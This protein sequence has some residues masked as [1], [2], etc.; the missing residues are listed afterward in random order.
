MLG[1]SARRHGR[2]G[3]RRRRHPER[4]GRLLLV[5]DARASG[6]RA[7]CRDGTRAR[8]NARASRGTRRRA[9]RSTRRRPPSSRTTRRSRE[10]L[11]RQWPLYFGRYGEREAAFVQ[12]LAG[13]VPNADALRRF[14]SDVLRDRSTSGRSSRASRRRRSCWRGDPGTSWRR[15]RLRGRS[16][17]AVA[18]A[19]ARGRAG[20]RPF[21]LRRGTGSVS[22]RRAL[23]F[24]GR[25]AGL[26]ESA[27]EAIR[28]GGRSSCR[29]TPSTASAPTRTGR[30]RCGELY[31]LKAARP[32][33]RARCSRGTSTCCSSS[34]PSCAAGRRRWRARLLPG[35]Y[36]LVLPN[37]ARRYRWLTGDSPGH[38][39]RARAGAAGPPRR[40][41]SDVGALVATSANLH[42]GPEPRRLEDVPVE[43]RAGAAAVVDG[44][45][46]PGTP[47][48]VLDLTGRG[49]EGPPRGRRARG[50]G[51]RARG[52]PPS[53][54]ST[55]TISRE[56]PSRRK[57]SST[58]ARPGSRRSIRRSPS[59][60]AA[61]SSAS[62]AQIELIASENFTWPAVLEAVGSVPTNK[63][64]EGYPGRRYYGGCEVVDEIEQTAIDR[65]KELFGAEHANVQPHAG[66]Q[67]NMAVYMA[68][69]AAGRHD[70]LAR[71]LARRPPHAR[72]QGQLLRPAVHD[73]PLRRL[74]RDERRRLRR[75]ARA[76]EGA[77]A[78]AD[79]LRRLRLPAHGRDRPLPRDRGRGRRAAALRH[80]PLRRARRGRAAPEPGRA[81]PTSSP[82][83]RTRRS[84]AR[85]PASSSAARST[86]RRS[87]A[88]SSRGCRAGRS[89]TR[90]R[91]RRRASGSRRPR[92]FRDYQRA[93]AR[94]RRR[95]RRRRSRTA[96]STS[97]PAAPTRTC[98]RSTC[99]RPT[100]RARTRRSGSPR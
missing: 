70:P 23:D 99:A 69:L 80:G 63:Y 29:P 65:A 28:A 96:G 52:S 76:R 94:E 81:L 51:A 88:R 44:G 8:R 5:D 48:T 73:R 77:P 85:A 75:R 41:S 39:R 27:V 26:I 31:R 54:G 36:T 71:A 32:T 43:I 64:A 2:D 45:E 42:G 37:P 49:A 24:R 9:R 66:A 67:T 4:V 21:H 35:P 82:R 7:G 13:L 57:R 74:A 56:W 10:N 18:D 90:S 86:R 60:S 15:P 34:C 61:S 59:C 93:G 62:A 22:R 1:F 72:A 50:R 11:A 84:P 38:D 19:E 79:R 91:P 55:S 12:T 58:C 97:S 47:S 40:S 46:L 98:S 30:R 95:A 100:G 53:A 14:N 6:R 33:S 78:E 68:A 20:S 87:T 16:P 3:L 92:P 17:S 25:S 83:R 89:C